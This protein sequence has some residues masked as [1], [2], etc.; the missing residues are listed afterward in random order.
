MSSAFLHEGRRHGGAQAWL[1]RS[2]GLK[3]K[4]VIVRSGE[5]ARVMVVV[6]YQSKKA[7]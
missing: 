6:L 3:I 4:R 2:D 5:Q 1:A 7:A